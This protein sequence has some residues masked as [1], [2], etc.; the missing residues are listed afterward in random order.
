M[1]VFWGFI[2]AGVHC[3]FGAVDGG[4]SDVVSIVSVLVGGVDGVED[5][6]RIGRVPYRGAGC[7]VP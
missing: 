1:W 7:Y 3:T 2:S 6:F 5:C 4:D